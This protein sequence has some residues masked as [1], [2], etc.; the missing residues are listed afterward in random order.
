MRLHDAA[1]ALLLLSVPLLAVS[2]LA[3]K[4]A[5]FDE[6][7][8][9]AYGIHYLHGGDL[10]MP[11]DH[12]PFFRLGAAISASLFGPPIRY[13][14]ELTWAPGIQPV[15]AQELLYLRNDA[16]AL[17]FWGRLPFVLFHLVL[18]LAVFRWSSLLWGKT[19]ALISAFFCCWS[20]T[21]LAHGRLIKN[22]LPVAALIFLATYYLYRT[23]EKATI[24]RVAAVGLLL[25]LALI[26]KRSAL[27]CLPVFALVVALHVWTTERWVLRLRATEHQLS[28]TR[29][30]TLLGLGILLLVFALGGLTIWTA[31][32]F[33]YAAVERTDPD[34][35]RKTELMEDFWRQQSLRSP[36]QR[37]LM[38]VTR[39]TKVLPES[40]LMG[41]QFR[42]KSMEGKLV[43][44]FGERST[45]GNPWYFPA[46]FLLKTPLGIVLL[47][48]LA[49]A[50]LLRRPRRLPMPALLAL[51]LFPAGY[52]GAAVLSDMTLG[53]RYL[54]PIYPFLFVLL[55]GS[56][57]LWEGSWTAR[58]LTTACALW[59]GARSLLVYP[60]YL[61]HF[62]ELAGGPRGGMRYLGD[63][64]L[65]WGQD[66][67]RLKPWMEEHGVERIKLG[68][69]G[70]ALPEYYGLPFTWLPSVG[71][72][73]DRA[74]ERV[75]HEG[76]YL[77]VSATCLQGFYFPDMRQYSFLE[78]F[79]PIDHIGHSIYLY[80]IVPDRYRESAADR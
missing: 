16:D 32:G 20:P 41:I 44:F 73:N 19:G 53:Q 26:T 23:L 46:A 74:G 34:L 17:L 7:I 50:G 66:L 8:S 2:S 13:D 51:S 77:A 12:L 57:R 21:L 14:G 33:R 4:S 6:P 49:L 75:I 80:H 61:A 15:A 36:W 62:N 59:F 79:E 25:G 72:R 24:G 1:L 10:G 9:L 30:K 68:Y 47:V 18:A 58:A 45:S 56:L 43:Y 69:F 48:P 35:A 22:D 28:R 60:D 52:F 63:S 76:D 37:T 38:Q 27:F 5:T 3:I 70:T 55:G 54:L 67:K 11:V 42:F 78:R 40:Y 65:D 39:V 31:Y 64:N 29:S 71:F